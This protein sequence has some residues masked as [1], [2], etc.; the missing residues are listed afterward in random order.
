MFRVQSSRAF[1]VCLLFSF[2]WLIEMVFGIDADGEQV[3]TVALK[4]MFVQAPLHCLALNAQP[5]EEVLYRT[6]D[7]L[8]EI[9]TVQSMDLQHW[10]VLSAECWVLQSE[11]ERT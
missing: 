10:C 4:D 11:K 3:V 7:G 9:A 2:T 8:E 5:G 6:K 1:L